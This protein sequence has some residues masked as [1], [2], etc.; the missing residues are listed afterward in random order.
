MI[1]KVDN[2][3]LINNSKVLYKDFFFFLSKNVGREGL[4]WYLSFFFFFFFEREIR[5]REEGQRER[6]KQTPH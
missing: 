3:V 6:E 1:F 4:V 5:S 2:S